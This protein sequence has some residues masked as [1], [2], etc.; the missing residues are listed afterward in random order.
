MSVAARNLLF[1][2]SVEQLRALLRERH[3]TV[4]G[5]KGFL[6]DRY[7]DSRPRATDKQLI[8][9]SQLMSEDYRL[10]IRPIDVSDTLR[11][12]LWISTSIE[13]KKKGS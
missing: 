11:A 4:S 8:L 1:R 13:L 6:V 10:V 5:A 2:F 9:M 7:L 3:C 12:R